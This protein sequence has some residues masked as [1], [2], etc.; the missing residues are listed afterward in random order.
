MGYITYRCFKGKPISGGPT[1]RSARSYGN[2]VSFSIS[3][4]SRSAAERAAHL[5]TS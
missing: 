1:S 4:K 2:E 5:L 3:E